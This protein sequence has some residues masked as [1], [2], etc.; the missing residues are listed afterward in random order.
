MRQ[1]L[2]EENGN[3]LGGDRFGREEFVPRAVMD[4]DLEVNIDTT[5]FYVTLRKDGRGRV[6]G[7]GAEG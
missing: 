6:G 4:L 1:D 3:V 2:A 5:G 7:G